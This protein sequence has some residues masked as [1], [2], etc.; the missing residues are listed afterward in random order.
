[1]TIRQVYEEAS[2]L[3]AADRLRVAALILNDIAV[4]PVD[5]SDEWSEQDLKEWTN[6]GM[7]RPGSPWADENDA[8]D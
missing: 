3:S 5:V 2:K 8:I 7:T 4:A 6:W 1:M